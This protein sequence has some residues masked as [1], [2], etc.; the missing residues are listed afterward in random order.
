MFKR[1]GIDNQT[2]HLVK[3]T[4]NKQHKSSI[5]GG[6]LLKIFIPPLM[7]K[8]PLLGFKVSNTLYPNSAVTV[9]NKQTKDH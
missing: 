6:P 7:L 2:R 4:V 8:P 9:E 5:N 1:S 3:T